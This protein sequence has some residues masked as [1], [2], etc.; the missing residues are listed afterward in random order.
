[1]VST[2][3][4]EGIFLMQHGLNRFGL[5][6]YGSVAMITAG[7]VGAAIGLIAQG[8]GTYKAR[9]SAL[10]GDAKTVK[11]MAGIGSATATL[12]GT[13]LTVNATFEGLK[14]NATKAE[15][16]DGGVGGVRGPAVADLTVTK[17]MKGTLTGTIDLTAPQIEHLKKGGLYVQIYS[18]KPTDGT[19]WG[20]LL[21]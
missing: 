8:A 2:K 12:A 10:P 14:T 3:R 19:L 13:K 17:A 6:R 21:P 20:W 7:L 5:K 11:D 1:M 15:L 9:L 4:R 16:R 18:E